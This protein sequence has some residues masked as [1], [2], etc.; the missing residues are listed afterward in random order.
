ML[1]SI[2]AAT[3]FWAFAV[4]CVLFAIYIASQHGHSRHVSVATQTPFSAAGMDAAP[5]SF[6]LD[7]RSEDDSSGD[8][9]PEIVLA[10]QTITAR[11]SVQSR[12]GDRIQS[13]CLQ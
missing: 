7:P 5:T 8:L 9:L 11:E 6:D 10:T 2:N 4:I 12:I 3:L 13:P 1:S